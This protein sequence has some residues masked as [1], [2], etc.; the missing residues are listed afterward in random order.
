M[1]VIESGYAINIYCGNK[2]SISNKE[3]MQIFQGETTHPETCNE[4]KMRE[5]LKG[6]IPLY[7]KGVWN[8]V[9]QDL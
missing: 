9:L 1:R 7:E 6:F 5:I 4:K 8:G 3:G 2:V